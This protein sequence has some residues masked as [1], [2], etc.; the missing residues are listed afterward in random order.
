MRVTGK[1]NKN[2]NIVKNRIHR[3]SIMSGKSDADFAV[4]H[5]PAN[6]AN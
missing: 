6:V 1:L 5:S 2:P 4:C 3:E